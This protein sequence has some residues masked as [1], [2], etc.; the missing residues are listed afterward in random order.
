MQ[1]PDESEKDAGSRKSSV[2]TSDD[3][4]VQILNITR[5][6]KIAVRAEVAGSGVKRSKGLLGRKGLDPGEGMWIVPCEAVHTFFM[7]FP[8]DL[9]Y[10]DK[11][12]CIKKVRS[13]VRPWRL[14]ACLSAHSILE[15]P[16]GAIRDSESQP[17]DIVRFEPSLQN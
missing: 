12:N 6:T 2:L 8:L 14:S 15:L 10:L 13:N 4:H 9:I 5:N 16:V 1:F 7:Q 17:G 3:G 11:K